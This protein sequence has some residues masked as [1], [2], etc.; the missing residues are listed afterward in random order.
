MRNGM[1]LGPVMDGRRACTVCAALVLASLGLAGL[2]GCSS[3]AAPEA[4]AAQ[5]STMMSFDLSKCQQVDAGI[6]KCPAVDK[7]VCN[8]DVARTDVECIRVAK[9]GSVYVQSR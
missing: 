5:K 7:P 2:S 6:F 1:N 4:T 8:P 9:D 3:S